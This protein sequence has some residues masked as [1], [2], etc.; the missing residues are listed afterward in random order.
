MIEADSARLARTQLREKGL[1]VVELDALSDT[2]AQGGSRNISLPFRKR[3][4]LS[5]VSLML[6]QLATLLEAGLPLEQAL[7]VLIEQGDNPSMRQVIAAMRS[8]VLA[9]NTLA[10]AMDKHRDTFPEIHRAL[11]N[12]GEA[13]GELATVMDKLASYSEAQQAL[14]QKISLAMVYPAIVITVAVLV[15][16]GLLLFVVPP[17]VEVFQQTRQALPLLTRALIALSDFLSATW[18]YLIAIFVVGGFG[19]QRALQQ[20]A[21]RYQFHLKLLQLPIV[22]KLIRGSNT[23]HMASTLSILVGSGVGLL[24]ALTAACGVL[25]NLP[26]RRALE[27]AATKVR[28]GVTLSRALAVSGLFPP[29]LVHL[30]ASGEQSGRLDTM[31]DRVA[32]Q[33]TQEVS[34]FTT[35]LTSILEPV[36]IL[37]MGAVVL[38][39]VLAILLPI[40]Q[41]NQMVK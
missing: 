15:V 34:G 3:I 4:P 35:A 24:T 5:E 29:V 23:A 40:I 9:G 14:Q 28:E 12:A 32:K 1:F 18:L 19:A 21:L 10:R 7:A 22:G 41:M 17:V 8:E 20:E 2:P 33:Q 37:F 11:I 13:S 6:R 36:L 30:I 39:I 27:D 31:L 38:L 26:M 16:G 25:T